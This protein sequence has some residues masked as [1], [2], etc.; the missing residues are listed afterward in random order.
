MNREPM[1]FTWEAPMPKTSLG[2]RL[3]R[4]IASWNATSD[5]KVP[6]SQEL[7]V[8]CSSSS[9]HAAKGRPAHAVPDVLD[10]AAMAL[11]QRVDA[12]EMGAL[13]PTDTK[14]ARSSPVN[15]RANRLDPADI[16]VHLF[17]YD[18]I[19]IAPATTPKHPAASQGP[20]L[21]LESSYG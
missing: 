15:I 10:A 8:G 21:S 4:L 7:R 17:A 11:T 18:R 1:P 13:T 5:G 20:S 3:K 2:A 9:P 14:V 6:R 16:P 12:L 19:L